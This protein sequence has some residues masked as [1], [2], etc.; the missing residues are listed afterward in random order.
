VRCR[1]NN[2]PCNIVPEIEKII[3]KPFFCSF[4]YFFI[5]TWMN[6]AFERCHKV[7]KKKIQ[8]WIISRTF[9]NITNVHCDVEN[10]VCILFPSFVKVPKSYLEENIMYP[11]T[12]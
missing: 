7:W 6:Q 9:Q 5:G 8:K 3:K 11:S 12:L 4:A 1:Q 10:A 2:F